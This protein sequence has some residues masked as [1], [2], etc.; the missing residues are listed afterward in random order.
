MA[1]I[2]EVRFSSNASQLGI[3]ARKLET[4]DEEMKQFQPNERGV[5]YLTGPNGKPCFDLI[6]ILNLQQLDGPIPISCFTKVSEWSALRKRSR[7]V[8]G[9]TLRSRTHG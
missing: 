9:P 7:P 3:A 8:A 1:L 5:V 2:C 4:L 6:S